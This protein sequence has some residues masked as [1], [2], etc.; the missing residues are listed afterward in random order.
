MEFVTVYTTLDRGDAEL[1]RG[2]LESADFTVNVK[3][4]DVIP[5]LAAGGVLLQVPEEEAEEARALL[6][7]RD[8]SNS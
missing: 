1:I 2:R 8:S 4:E 3:N 6:K 7:Y 5:G